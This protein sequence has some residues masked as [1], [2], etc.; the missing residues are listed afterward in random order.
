MNK[1]F[2]SL[3]CLFIFHNVLAYAQDLD[4]AYNYQ[5]S[6]YMLEDSLGDEYL[7]DLRADFSNSKRTL[8][9]LRG[10]LPEL[11]IE[12]REKFDFLKN[13]DVPMSAK[14][15]GILFNI[16]AKKKPFN[17]SQL[18]GLLASTIAKYED[19]SNQKVTMGTCHKWSESFKNSKGHLMPKMMGKLLTALSLGVSNQYL[20]TGYESML[21]DWL[22]IQE[23]NSVTIDSI[24]NQALSLSNGDL[25]L[26][27]LS[28]ENV[29]SRYWRIEGRENIKYI[30]NLHPISL[31]L[32][33]HG[34]K[35]GSWYH[36][37]GML[38]Y[39]YCSNSALISSAIARV[40]T[41]GSHFSYGFIS[42]V[43]QDYINRIAGPAGKK[44]R[45]ILK[46]N[47]QHEYDESEKLLSHQLFRSIETNIVANK[48]QLKSVNNLEQCKLKVTFLDKLKNVLAKVKFKGVQL[49]LDPV[50]LDHQIPA[51]TT[52]VNIL[53][54][55][56]L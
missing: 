20:F 46:K 33:D 52:E 35:F 38:I 36:L 17:K 56:C 8:R 32:N 6:H 5:Q 55:G 14:K 31:I 26:A 42:E 51:N 3:V 21:Q 39:G 40:E 37:W 54:K 13:L 16:E 44:I 27:M 1:Y 24:L 7:A 25:Y 22:L 49:S 23:K 29:L 2:L 47:L 41:L 50:T 43:Q 19:A 10:E 18:V 15:K 48:I 4:G 28:I 30:E 34:D 9:M 12:D 11:L 45:T 53:V